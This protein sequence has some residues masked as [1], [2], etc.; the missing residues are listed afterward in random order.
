MATPSRSRTIIATVVL[1]TVLNPLDGSMMAVALPAIRESFAATAASATWLITVYYLA[2]AVAQPIMGRIADLLGA[3]RVFVGGLLLVAVACSLAQ[4]APSI[5]WLIGLR[6]VQAVGS[7][8]A[9][10][11]GL[12]IVRLSLLADPAASARAVGSIT[13]INSLAAVAGPLVGGAMV[14]VLGWRGPFVFGIPFALFG[15]VIAVITLP[16]DSVVHREAA[17]VS[18]WKRTDALGAVL[19]GTA[20][21]ALQLSIVGLATLWML[22]WFGAFAVA[23]VMLILR[24]K[25]A[26]FPF[27]DSDVLFSDPKTPAVLVQYLLANFTF[28]AVIVSLPTWLQLAHSLQPVQSGLVT[29]PIAV[30]GVTITLLLSRF[31]YGG[32][33]QRVLVG[34]ACVSLGGAVAMSFLTPATPLI[35]AALF[36]VAAASPNNLTTLTLQ[37]SLYKRV[38]SAATGAATGLFQTFRYVGATLA[39]TVVGLNLN[40]TDPGQLTEGMRNV[41]LCAVLAGGLALVIALVLRPGTA[42]TTQSVITPVES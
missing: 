1:G 9:F 34:M 6:L 4:F 39:S 13:W 24:E 37:S 28:F 27:I 21:A 30:I 26:A 22:I 10:P 32:H 31:V 29:F 16:R 42:P 19:L 17:V 11:A 7:S 40:A 5:E 38:D 35:A 18:L 2:G 25:H 15:A 12:I 33:G 8:V 23:L 41:M 14:Q 36:A 20:I 3:R